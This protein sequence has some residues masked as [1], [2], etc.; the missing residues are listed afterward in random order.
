MYERKILMDLGVKDLALLGKYHYE[1]AG[2]C[3][4]PHFHHD[5]LE[6]VYCHSG[7]QLYETDNQ[8]FRIKGGEIFITF[9]NEIHST[10]QKPEEKG[11]IYWLQ[12]YIHPDRNRLLQLPEEES[13]LLINKLLTIEQRHFK[14]D[15]KVH[16]IFEEMFTVAERFSGAEKQLRIKQLL[17]QLI[18][19]IIDSPSRNISKQKDNKVAVV[20][21]FIRDNLT[22]SLC[23]S[24]LAEVVY[25]SESR[26]KSWFK[27]QFGMPAME[28]IQRQKINKAI[29]LW[30]QNPEK[31]IVDIAYSLNF[32]SPQH[33]STLFKKYV[34]Q[35][36][37]LFI[38]SKLAGN[39][40]E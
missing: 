40:V 19:L 29:E 28:Y 11:I 33:F 14:A 25:L 20:S 3:L 7:T 9:P 32:S 38:K 36:P 5:R 6:I 39:I 27:Q 16:K 37:M 21:S 26:F 17:L 24:G 8:P 13:A 4:E 12:I 22:K 1:K 35:S 2:N 10:N 23:I 15:T 30:N 31:K 34:G 18:I